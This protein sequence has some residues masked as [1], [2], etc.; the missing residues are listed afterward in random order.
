MILHC[1]NAMDAIYPTLVTQALKILT[2][3][4]CL[5]KLTLLMVLRPKLLD[6]QYEILNLRFLMPVLKLCKHYSIY[7]KPTIVS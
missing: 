1:D 5:R 4:K 3:Q 2:A 7:N 6:I